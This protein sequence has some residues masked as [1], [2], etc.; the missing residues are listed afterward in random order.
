LNHPPPTVVAAGMADLLPWIAT[1]AT[2]TAAFMTAAN[3]GARITGYGFAVFL[4]GSLCWLVIGL[5]SNQPALLWTNAVLTLL[6]IFGIWRWLGRQAKV[7]EGT[8]A[9][10]DASERAAGHSLF[11]ISRLTQ[12]AVA[13]S[14]GPVG[15]CVDAMADR[16]GGRIVYVG[17]SEGGVA[18]VGETLRRVPWEAV[19][20]D[21]DTVRLSLREAEFDQMES[22]EKDQWPV[23]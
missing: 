20:I 1:A 14:G 15:T 10:A 23:R 8:K 4:I 12:A 16:D 5:T 18:G 17:V 21:G 3:L 22:F 19:T 7:E 11:P 6:N 13:T 2:V 9:A